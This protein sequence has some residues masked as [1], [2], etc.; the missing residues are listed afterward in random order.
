MNPNIQHLISLSQIAAERILSIYRQPDCEI[1]FKRDKSL[2]TQ[3][4]LESHTII[5]DELKKQYPAIPVIS[6]ES[7]ELHDYAVRKNFETF[8]LVDPL[9]GTKEFVNRNDEFTINIAL[10]HHGQPI[11][12]VINAPALNVIYY[13]EEG[14][15]AYKISSALQF[16]DLIPV[17]KLKILLIH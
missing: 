3:A 2:L 12:G 6:E 11:L 17:N 4:D 16:H 10:I 14:K 8:F 5:C 7:P 13:A 1:R 15:G 9:D